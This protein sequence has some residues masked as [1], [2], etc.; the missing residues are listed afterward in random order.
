MQEGQTEITISRLPAVLQSDSLRVEVETKSASHGLTVFDVVHSPP[1]YDSTKRY[2][3]GSELD[4]LNEKVATLDARLIVLGTQRGILSSF[5]TSLGANDTEG[6]TATKSSVETLEAFLDVFST[7]SDKIHEETRALQIERNKLNERIADIR[8]TERTEREESRS[9]G[10]SVVLLAME[11]GSAELVLSYGESR[12]FYSLSG[13]ALWLTWRLVVRLASWSSLYDVRADL[14][15]TSAGSGSGSG[16]TIALQY[17]ANITQN[18]GEDW[19]GVVLTLS[20]ASPLLRSNIPVL[21]PWKI[22]PFVPPP[23]PQPGVPMARMAPERI[24]MRQRGS[25]KAAR[26]QLAPQ[27]VLAEDDEELETVFAAGGPKVAVSEGAIS[28]TFEIDG[29]STIPSDNTSHKV[30]IAV[31]LPL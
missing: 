14:T 8:K 26:K 10:V 18:T 1:T 23:P 30:S 9:T 21:Q 12:P 19:D 2:D 7:R 5:G 16:P 24:R 28:S 31:S 22:G 11:D 6:S 3:V 4:A 20:T 15:S 25:G 13:C 17:R 29:L 27:T